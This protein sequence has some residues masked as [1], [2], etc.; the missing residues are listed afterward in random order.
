M[1]NK[2]NI[3]NLINLRNQVSSPSGLDEIPHTLTMGESLLTIELCT[4]GAKERTRSRA[5]LAHGKN[6]NQEELTI[7]DM[8][9]EL[10]QPL[11]GSMGNYRHSI[12]QDRKSWA[13]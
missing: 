11:Q 8:D 12:A 13:M 5:A 2:Y 9:Q 10:T 7:R 1:S 6:V 4:F 3:T